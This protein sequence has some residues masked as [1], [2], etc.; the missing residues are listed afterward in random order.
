MSADDDEREHGI[1]FGDLSEALERLEYPASLEDV[2][3]EVGDHDLEVPDGTT[4]V[5][6]ALDGLQGETFDSP[7]AVLEAVKN[8]IGGE[9]VGR[10]GYSD[11]GDPEGDEGQPQE[12]F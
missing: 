1:E 7:E 12:S 10:Q 2:R 4:T 3:R 6:E 5:S 9:A 11:R 8:M